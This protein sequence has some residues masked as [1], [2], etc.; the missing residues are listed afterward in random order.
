MKLLERFLEDRD[1]HSQFWRSD[2]P[3]LNSKVHG[4]PLVYLDNAATT[5]KPRMVID[6]ERNYYFHYNSNVHRGIHSLSQR[7][8]CAYED[9]RSRVQRLINAKSADEIIFVR[10]TTEAINMVAQCYGRNKFKTGDEIILS[11]MEH[12]SNIVPWQ[13]LCHQTE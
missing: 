9:A 2:F 12:H 4:K 7:A 3:I 1:I 5:Q 10:G 8:T 11:E 13:M 6:A